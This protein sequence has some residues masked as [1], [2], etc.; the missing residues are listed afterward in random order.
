MTGVSEASFSA[1]YNTASGA[2]WSSAVI[3]FEKSNDG[4][5]WAALGGGTTLTADGVTADL[6]VSCA[7]QVRARVSTA[8]TDAGY[9]TITMVGLVST[10]SQ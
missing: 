2:A 9:A 8:Q 10:D 1:Y 5:V 4:W 7:A 3:T 6:D